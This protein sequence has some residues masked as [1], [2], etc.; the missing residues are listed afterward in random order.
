MDE[1]QAVAQALN[2]HFD[3]P[4]E[5]KDRGTAIQLLQEEGNVSLVEKCLTVW[6]KWN[7]PKLWT[8]SKFQ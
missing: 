6:A 1:L 4:V 7:S 2:A 3:G 8:V 5:V